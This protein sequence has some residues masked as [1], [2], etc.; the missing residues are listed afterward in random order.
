M[1]I[2]MS[3]IICVTNRKLCEE[4]FLVRIERIVRTDVKAVILRE[5][6][7]SDDEYRKLAVSVLDICR[8]YRKSCILHSHADIAVELK[9]DGVHF[10]MDM[11]RNMKEKRCTIGVSC[12]SVAEAVEAETLEADY[13][14][15]GHIFATD[16]KKGLEPRGL[17]FLKKVCESVDIP[18][19]AIGGI[20]SNNIESVIDAGASGSSIMSGFMRGEN[21]GY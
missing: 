11:L 2:C 20:N 13:I 5:K 1:I 9:A 7:L 6:D 14:I 15:A 16:C 4:D 3:D 8:K 19:Y 12:H 21:F 18:V 17:D 10:T